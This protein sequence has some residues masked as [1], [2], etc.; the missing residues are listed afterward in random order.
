[1]FKR[2]S[3]LAGVTFCNAS[4][5]ELRQRIIRDLSRQGMLENGTC[6]IPLREPNNPYDPNAV[7]VCA[8]DGRQLGYLRKEDAAQVAEAMDSGGNCQIMVNGV[9]GGDAE[10]VYGVNIIIQ[11]EENNSDDLLQSKNLIEAQNRA[12]SAVKFNLESEVKSA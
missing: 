11:I 2:F 4:N 7:A 9:T 5:G 3:K 1:M 6:L 12:P 10:N 8:L